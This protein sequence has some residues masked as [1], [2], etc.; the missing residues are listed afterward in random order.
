VYC[1]KGITFSVEELSKP[2]NLLPISSYSDIY[3]KLILSD[4]NIL[5]SQAK[6]DSI[7]RYNIIAKSEAL[8]LVNFGY[9][10]FFNGV[11]QAYADHRPLVLSPDMIWLLIS[12]GFARHVSSDP[13]KM[14]KYFVDFLDK[15]TLEVTAKGTIVWE[16]IFPQFTKQ[17]GEYTG[18][19][20]IDLLSADFSTTTPVEKVASEITIMEAM[21]P[22]FEY[23]V[24][25]VICGIPDFSKKMKLL[26][27]TGKKVKAERLWLH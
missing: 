5:P 20:L 2:E 3:V 14:R 27:C 1:Q 10:S 16:D 15:K 18:K 21:K 24:F 19:D 25:Y 9:H 26:N 8:N 11:Y 17:I 12:Q 13:E 6:K 7:N 22:Y 4:A 23:V